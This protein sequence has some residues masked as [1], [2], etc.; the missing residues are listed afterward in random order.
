[1][2]RALTHTWSLDIGNGKSGKTGQNR[3]KTAKRPAGRKRPRQRGQ[4]RAGC[5]ATAVSTGGKCD[6]RPKRKP[7]DARGVKIEIGPLYVDL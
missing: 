5:V 2:F 7:G 3:P 4:N 6:E 1:M